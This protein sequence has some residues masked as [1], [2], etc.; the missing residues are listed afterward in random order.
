MDDIKQTKNLFKSLTKDEFSVFYAANKIRSDLLKKARKS[1]YPKDKVL[2][3]LYSNLDNKNILYAA[4]NEKVVLP[5]YT[6]F[7][8]QKKN[9]DRSTLLV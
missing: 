2:M 3:K 5:I 1:Y 8:E 7:V 4:K 6:L 9:I